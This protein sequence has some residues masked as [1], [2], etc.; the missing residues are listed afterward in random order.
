MSRKFQIALCIVSIFSSFMLYVTLNVTYGFAAFVALLMAYLSVYAEEIRAAAMA[1][2][3]RERQ[4]V[5][6]RNQQDAE[7]F[8]MLLTREREIRRWR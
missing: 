2:R 5:R 3:E 1:K 7:A 8:D 6:L 4:K